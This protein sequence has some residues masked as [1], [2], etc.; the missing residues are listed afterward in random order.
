MK[1]TNTQT[2]SPLSCIVPA[3]IPIEQSHEREGDAR[4]GRCRVGYQENALEEDPE[5][6]SGQ[7]NPCRSI[8]TTCL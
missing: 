1:R 3:G 5:V 7:I 6:E 2:V 4:A 8:I